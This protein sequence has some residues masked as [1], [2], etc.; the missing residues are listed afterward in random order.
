MFLLGGIIFTIVGVTMIIKPYIIFN[1]TEKWKNDYNTEP[2]N[3]YVFSTR[4]G[5]CIITFI[6]VSAIIMFFII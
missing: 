3:L 1:I 5:G 4:F 2:S 6:G